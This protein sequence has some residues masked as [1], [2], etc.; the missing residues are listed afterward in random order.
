MSNRA[1]VK[2]QFGE[3]E[4]NRKNKFVFADET[5]E[6]VE[7][8]KELIACRNNYGIISWFDPAVV[9]ERI[10]EKSNAIPN[11]Y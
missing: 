3:V 5:W 10:H 9:A 2:C 4:V 11:S 7:F 8:D 6:V 1:I